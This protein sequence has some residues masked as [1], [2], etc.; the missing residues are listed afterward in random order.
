MVDPI[1]F[2]PREDDESWG[3]QNVSKHYQLSVMNFKISL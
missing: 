1:R 2:M 3:S